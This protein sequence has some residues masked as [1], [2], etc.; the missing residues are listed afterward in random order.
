MPLAFVA[1]ISSILIDLWQYLYYSCEQ[2]GQYQRGKTMKLWIIYDAGKNILA[3]FCNYRVNFD[4][5]DTGSD[6]LKD[7][8][9]LILH[10]TGSI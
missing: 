5:H 1:M 8:C 2:A 6:K 4:P 9:S 10:F 7:E 3:V